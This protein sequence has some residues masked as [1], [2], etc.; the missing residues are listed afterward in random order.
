MKNV[1]KKEMGVLK[2]PLYSKEAHTINS[3]KFAEK[4]LMGIQKQFNSI[5]SF[6]IQNDLK[7]FRAYRNRKSLNSQKKITFKTSED[8]R[9]IGNF[10]KL[11]IY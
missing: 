5:H 11:L 2:I 10:Q 1:L 4:T 3:M 8:I 9:S 7:F 6:L